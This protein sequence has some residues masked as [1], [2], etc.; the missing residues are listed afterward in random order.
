MAAA[1]PGEAVAT[2]RGGWHPSLSHHAGKSLTLLRVADA[3]IPG[4][5]LHGVRGENVHRIAWEILMD[6]H[7]PD[8]IVDKYAG[9]H[10]LPGMQECRKRTQPTYPP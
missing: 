1:G 2:G 7:G 5:I 4:G 3:S 8:G 10:I 6:D 9:D